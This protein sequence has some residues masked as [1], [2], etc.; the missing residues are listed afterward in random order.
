MTPG[1]GM[2]SYHLPQ[3]IDDEE[4][5]IMMVMMM[6]MIYNSLFQ[7]QGDPYYNKQKKHSRNKINEIK[8]TQLILIANT[9]SGRHLCCC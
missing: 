7:A 4:E 3:Y 2:I 5:D 1:P 9:F 6:M 8:N